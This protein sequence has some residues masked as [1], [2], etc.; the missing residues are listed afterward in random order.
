MFAMVMD[1]VADEVRHESLWTMI[2]V[3]DIVIWTDTREQVEENLEKSRYVLERRGMKV[4]C[5]NSTRV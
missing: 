4:T 2:F 3:D 5:S 1:S